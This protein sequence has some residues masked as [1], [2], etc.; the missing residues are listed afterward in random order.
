MRALWGQL[1]GTLAHYRVT[2]PILRV[3]DSF[4]EGLHSLGQ[5]HSL[6]KEQGCS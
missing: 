6:C 5:E 3:S 2:I 4:I 1:L